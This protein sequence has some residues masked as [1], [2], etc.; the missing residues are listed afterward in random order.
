MV[1][2]IYS[3][4]YWMRSQPSADAWIDSAWISLTVLG[5]VG[6]GGSEVEPPT[7]ALIWAACAWLGVA[8]VIVVLLFRGWLVVVVVIVGAVR[9]RLKDG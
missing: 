6:V 2:S 8:F 3:S 1:S 5:R 4:A 7:I 9:V